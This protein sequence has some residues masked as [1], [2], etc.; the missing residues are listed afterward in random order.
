MSYAPATDTQQAIELIRVAVER[1]VTF[2]GAAEVYAPNV[3]HLI[4]SLTTF[5]FNI[6]VD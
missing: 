6:V 1:G 4:G 3:D 2:V 5:G